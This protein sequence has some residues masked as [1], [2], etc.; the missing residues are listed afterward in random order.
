MASKRNA[1][2]FDAAALPGPARYGMTDLEFANALARLITSGFQPTHFTKKLYLR[3]M[4][5]FQHIAHYD[6]HGFFAE[7][8]S[9]TE[10]QLAF[11]EH[12]LEYRS[13]FPDQPV[14]QIIRAWI[15]RENLY[16]QQC[17][18]V[19]GQTEARERKLL[20]RLQ[21]KYEGAPLP[22]T[23]PPTALTLSKPAPSHL[24]QTQLEQPNLFALESAA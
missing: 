21:Q 4:N 16:E 17:A 8:F 23:P 6:Q 13:W 24:V 18:I 3:L 1:A 12:T 20:A 11:L 7:W 5:Q 19:A 22:V 15:K 10:R 9:S 2:P 14:E